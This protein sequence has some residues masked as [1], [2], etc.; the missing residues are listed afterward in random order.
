[1]TFETAAFK[2]SCG[3]QCKDLFY[4]KNQYGQKDVNSETGETATLRTVIA[5]LM[6]LSI[7]SSGCLCG[8]FIGHCLIQ[9]IRFKK[10]A[11]S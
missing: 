7:N 9:A 2:V 6:M 3:F 11:A 10:V 1:M 8:K 5:M 4:N